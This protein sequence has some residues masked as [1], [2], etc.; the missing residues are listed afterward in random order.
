[1]SKEH[2]IDGVTRMYLENVLQKQI[3]LQ[4]LLRLSHSLMIEG[5]TT[6]LQNKVSQS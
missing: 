2:T 6:K 5:S 3:L 4:K 1:M